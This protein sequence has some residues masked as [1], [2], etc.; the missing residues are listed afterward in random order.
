MLSVGRECDRVK[1]EDEDEGSE[2]K[3]KGKGRKG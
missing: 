3:S 2:W 1:E